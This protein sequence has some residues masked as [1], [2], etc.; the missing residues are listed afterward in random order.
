M[1]GLIP[2]FAVEVLEPELLERL[3][4]FG[5]R[6]EWF[7]A[8]RPQLASLVSHWDVP[9][10]GKRRLLSLLRGHR[11][12]CLLHR[13][14]DEEEFLSPHGIRSLS[15]AHLETPF[16]FAHAGKEYTVHYT[17]A[18][19]DSG[20]FGGNSNWRGPIWMPLNYLLVESLQKFHR[21]YGD[22]FRVPC[23]TGS[24]HHATIAEVA[25]DL[26]QRLIGLFVCDPRGRRPALGAHDKL[27]S[28]PQFRDHVLFY[29]YFHGETGRGVGASHQTGWTGLVA[30]LIRAQSVGDSES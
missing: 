9:G 21:Y 14:L 30:E 10:V 11:M 19:S 26:S 24:E 3:P 22:R 15:K 18:E 6:L 28:D 25:S 2:L 5:A 4:A 17:P 23:P 8:N 27:H 1:V 12:R 29:E 20:L 7:L 16:R 13:L